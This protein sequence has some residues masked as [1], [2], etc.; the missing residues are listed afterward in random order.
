LLLRADVRA[1]GKALEFD[2]GVLNGI[3][4]GIDHMT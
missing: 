3:S 4:V 2:E 1:V